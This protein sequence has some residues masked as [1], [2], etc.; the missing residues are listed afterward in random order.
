MFKR[1]FKKKIYICKVRSSKKCIAILLTID[2]Y[3]CLKKK[4]RK[5]K[6]EKKREEGR[7]GIYMNMNVNVNVISKTLL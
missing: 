6:R 4:K 7:G 3:A 1:S 5:G 2:I